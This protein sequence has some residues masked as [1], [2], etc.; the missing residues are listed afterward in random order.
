LALRY[1]FS[2]QL[3]SYKWPSWLHP[4]FEKQR[5]IWG[6]KI[7]FLDVL[8]PLNLDRVIYIDS[9]QIVRTDL[10]ELMRMNFGT[11]PYAFT[12]FCDSRPETNPFRFW[13]TGFWQQKLGS[14]HKYHISAL[15][16]INLQQFRK[17][18]AG[19]W[20]RYDYD[21]LSPDPGSLA[22]LDQDLPNYRQDVI[23][24]YSLPQE[25]L[26]CE[27]WCSDESL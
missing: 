12:P 23:P 5:I 21:A 6:N 8:F 22:N 25:W 3:I 24:I 14:T 16:A 7:L 2:Y 4:Q 15:F 20:L 11:A 26:W 18:A 9:D 1:N 17:L 13:K 10:I 19:D 27:T